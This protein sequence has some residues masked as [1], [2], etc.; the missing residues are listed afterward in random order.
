MIDFES[1]FLINNH[2]GDLELLINYLNYN[3]LYFRVIISENL[4]KNVIKLFGGKFIL[5]FRF[6]KNYLRNIKNIDR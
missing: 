2:F 1:I 3:L 4:F 5:N 6:F